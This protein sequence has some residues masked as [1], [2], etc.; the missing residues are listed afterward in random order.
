MIVVIQRASEA[1]V[2]IGGNVKA[3][4][5]IGLMILLGIEE[6]DTEE[7]IAWLSKKI[8]NLRIFPDENEVMNKSL[9]DIDGEILLISQFTL[10]AST[11]K[12]NRPSYIKAAKPDIAIPLYE[13]MITALQTELDK[14]I[15]TGEFGADMKVSLVNDGPVTIVMDSKN[16]V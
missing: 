8:V 16:K 14:P 13:K 15:G 1:S 3:E 9:L 11:K 4:I 5:G 2:K 12:G 7:D 10:H 6:A